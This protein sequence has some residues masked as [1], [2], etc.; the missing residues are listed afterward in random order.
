[1]KFKEY[2]AR[3]IKSNTRNRNGHTVVSGSRRVEVAIEMKNRLAA[4]IYGI[5]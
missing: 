5:D 3:A 4:K 1:M 2:A